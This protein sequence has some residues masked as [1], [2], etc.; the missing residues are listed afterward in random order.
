MNYT[1]TADEDLFPA[2]SANN[3]FNTAEQITL[4]ATGT[5]TSAK[6]QWVGFGDA[7]DYYMFTTNG[8]G[9]ITVDFNMQ[10]QSTNTNYKVTLYS[11]TNG[12]TKQLKSV[13][14]KGSLGSVENI[15]KNDVLALAGTYYLVV[16]SGDKGKGKQNGY[17]DFV[18]NDDYFPAASANNSFGTAEQ[19][20][21]NAAGSGSSAKNQWVGFGDAAD[22]YMFTTTENGAISIDFNMQQDQ[23]HNAA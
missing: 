19:I 17:Y 11:L 20:A 21:L 4:D 14:L 9:A 12:K 6:S 5:G 13:T 8:N 15:F 16:E 2:A 1:I 23:H 7:A 10:Q 3:S 18:I 22:Y